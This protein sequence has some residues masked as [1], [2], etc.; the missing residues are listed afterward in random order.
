MPQHIKN[1]TLGLK[2]LVLLFLGYAC[3]AEALP[4]D[5]TQSL[6]I[7]ADTSQV[8]YKTGSNN[9]QGN[10]KIDQGSS[11]LSADRLTTKNN[12][13][14]K[15][16]E[17]IAYGI[18]QLA[19]YWTTPKQGDKLFNAF[20]QVITLY[21]QK[22]LVVLE[23]DVIVTQGKNSFHGPTLIYNLY[24]QTVTAPATKKG[25]STIVIEPQDLT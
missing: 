6:H 16:D 24:D 20:A 14:H 17:A 2:T 11:H 23:G 8:N 18:Y 9:Y 25:L 12:K 7:S 15:M 22:G 21:P 3:C 19:H 13:Q 5:I 1:F 10:V 4:S